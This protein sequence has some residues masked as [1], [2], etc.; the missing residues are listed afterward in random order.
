MNFVTVF[1]FIAAAAKLD[2]GLG[3]ALSVYD[4]E[5]YDS[6][7]KGSFV[8]LNARYSLRY[9]LSGSRNGP[10]FSAALR[11][12]FGNE[13]INFGRESRT[14]Y[15]FGPTLEEIAGISIANRV[16]IEAGLFQVKLFGSDMLPTDTGF[17]F[18]TYIG[19]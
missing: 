17:S 3:F 13:K 11:L 16:Y 5:N 8:G 2:G 6:M 1:T 4:I 18:G 19:F 15:F 14:N 9:F 7:I 10:Y 12:T